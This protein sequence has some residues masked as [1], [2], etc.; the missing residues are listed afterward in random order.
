MHATSFALAAA[1]LAASGWFFLRPPA[2]E[3]A[4]AADGHYVLVV[5]GDRNALTITHANAKPDPWGGVPKG[6]TSEWQLTIRDAAGALLATVP[7]DVSPF[8]TSEAG[9]GQPVRVEG[10]I[11]RDSRIGMLVN[12]PRFAEAASYTFSRPAIAG[13]QAELVIGAAPAAHVRDLAGDAR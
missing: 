2:V 10:C 1:T 5:E 11:V 4:A 13:Q 9:Q 8:V 12:V 3:A 7:L 6:F